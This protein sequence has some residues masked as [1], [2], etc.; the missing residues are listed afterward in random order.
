MAPSV[1]KKWIGA[2][3]SIGIGLVLGQIG[4]T[5]GR[6]VVRR[7]NADLRS[8]GT[9][10][11]WDAIRKQHYDE[12]KGLIGNGGPGLADVNARQVGGITPLILAVQQDDPRMVQELLNLNADIKLRTADGK[13]ALDIARELNRS[14]ILPLLH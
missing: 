13:S 7:Y 10:Y 1:R 8:E 5:I 4:L 2:I 12:V 6:A 14:N 9:E 11:M 3:L